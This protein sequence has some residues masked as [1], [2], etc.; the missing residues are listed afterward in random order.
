MRR[1]LIAAGWMLALAGTALAQQNQ[2]QGTGSE[3]GEATE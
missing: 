1:T 2:G 3:A